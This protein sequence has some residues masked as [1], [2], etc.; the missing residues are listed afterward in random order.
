MEHVALVA[1]QP[2]QLV[3]LAGAVQ[4]LVLGAAPCQRALPELA[5]AGVDKAVVVAG[6]GQAAGERAAATRAVARCWLRARVVRPTSRLVA[7]LHKNR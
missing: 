2:G 4:V 5:Q 3:W 7:S 6:P 1:I